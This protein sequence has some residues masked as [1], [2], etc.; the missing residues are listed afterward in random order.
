MRRS[1]L[2]SRLDG[3]PFALPDILDRASERW[4]ARSPRTRFVLVGCALA[5]VV[6]VG[7]S[8]AAATPYGPLRTVHVATRDLPIGHEV[9]PGDVRRTDWPL[10]LI[11]TAATTDPT[12]RLTAPLPAGAVLTDG[13]LGSDGIAGQLPPDT[14]AVALPAEAVPTL[15]PGQRIDVVGRDVQG[16]GLVLARGARVVTVEAEVV[17]LAVAREAAA[18]VAAAAPTGAVSVVVLAP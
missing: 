7:L 2:L 15:A 4:W 12:G 3:A 1:Q 10:E 5:L 11:P 16:V 9:S 17:W 14:V 8:H 6:L 13:H 18:D